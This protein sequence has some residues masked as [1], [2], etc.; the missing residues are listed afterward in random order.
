MRRRDR[1]V[2]EWSNED[3]GLWA[4]SEGG[5]PGRSVCVG[6]CGLQ[7][8]G[9]NCVPPR[10]PTATT[11]VVAVQQ[12]DGSWAAT[13]VNCNVSTIQLTP[14]M[15]RAEVVRLV[16]RVGIKAA[17]GNGRVLVNLET[18]FWADTRVDRS[19]GTVMLLGHQVALTIHVESVSWD[20]GDGAVGSSDGPGRPF[21]DSDHCG[22]AQ[23]PGWFGHTYAATG[24]FAVTATVRWSGEYAVD[25]AAAQPIPGIVTGPEATSTIQA[26]EA[27]GVLVPDPH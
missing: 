2:G 13:A 1:D 7:S 5:G 11:E 12:S 18:L 15:L 27:R 20:F 23:C 19:L 17:P 24:R 10:D 25:G 9:L 14:Q 21:G 16:P 26:V 8:A 22:T 4:I 6:C 3:F